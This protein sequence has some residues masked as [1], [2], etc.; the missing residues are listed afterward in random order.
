ML[1]AGYVDSYPHNPFIRNAQPVQLM[2]QQY[3]DP[4][5]STFPDGRQMG[6]RFGANGN[7]MGQ[8]L[9]DARWLSWEYVDPLTGKAEQLPTW[10]NIQYEFYDAWTTAQRRP[11]LPGAFFYKAMGEVVPVGPS[12]N[13]RDNQKVSV[14][15]KNTIARNPRAADATYPASLG[16]Y[17]L[18]AWGSLR[19]KGQDVLGEEPLVVFKLRS[20]TQNTSPGMFVTSQPPGGKSGANPGKPISRN[21]TEMLGIPAW[22]RGVN[23]SHIGP[24][25][26]SPYGPSTGP[27]QQVSYGNANGVRDGIILVLTPGEN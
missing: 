5:R 17:M 26:G 14:G 3:G 4:L 23:R 9:C 16:D 11:Y 8:V 13:R 25:W 2:Q 15:G 18:G 10:S 12:T 1:R 7:A 24:L 19:S 22:T 20:R 21:R 27:E 6:T